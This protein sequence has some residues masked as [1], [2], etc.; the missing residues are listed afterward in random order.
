M[1]D[2]MPGQRF[3][4][5]PTPTAPDAGAPDPWA[6]S[7]TTSAPV[8]AQRYRSGAPVLALIL[9]IVV[10]VVVGVL[11]WAGTRPPPP[12]AGASPST[13]SSQPEAG[14]TEPT[15]SPGWQGIKFAPGGANISGYWQI[16]AGDWSTDKVT[17]TTT[18]TVDQGT[19]RY[20]F[21]ALNNVTRDLYQPTDGTMVT[22]TLAA[23]ESQTG[24]LVFQV[25]P[26][27]FTLYLATI[28]GVQITALV[29]KG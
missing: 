5:Q 16:S 11:V 1:N 13:T 26:G 20:T 6:A 24:T 17:V 3:R 14:P 7:A 18:I 15:P 8:T 27:D 22:G 28:K 4:N 12:G 10:F 29:V 23:G 9:A 21:F 2:R 25:P 19:L